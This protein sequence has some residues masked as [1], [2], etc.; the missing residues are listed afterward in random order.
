MREIEKL[1]HPVTTVTESAMT[2]VTFKLEVTASA[3]Q[4]PSTCNAIGLFL[5]IG[6]I[7][8]SLTVDISL[9]PLNIVSQETSETLARPA[10]TAPSL[11]HHY[12]S[13]LPLLNHLFDNRRSQKQG[14]PSP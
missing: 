7:N 9:L 3:E 11:S 12:W 13:A 4:M 10:R 14:R 8:E 6:S 5:K 2:R 1:E